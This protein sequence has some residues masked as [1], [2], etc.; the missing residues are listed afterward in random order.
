MLRALLSR[1]TG[2]HMAYHQVLCMAQNPDVT[3]DELIELI[4]SVGLSSE[5]VAA[6][7]PLKTRTNFRRVMARHFGYL[8][9]RDVA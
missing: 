8:G 4:R 9:K 7:W 3:R 1:I 5:S 2:E 6:R